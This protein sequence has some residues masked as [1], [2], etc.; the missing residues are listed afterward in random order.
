MLALYEP[1]CT[2]KNIYY[3]EEKYMFYFKK[4]S[5][6]NIKLYHFW[7]SLVA[8]QVKDPELSLLRLRSLL[9]YVLDLCIPSLAQELPLP[10][11]KKKKQHIY[12]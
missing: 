8:Q 4:Y 12:M 2:K 9:W 10:E 5:N 1:F 6:V 3:F 7:S 11:T